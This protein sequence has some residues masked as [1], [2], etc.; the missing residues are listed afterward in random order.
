VFWAMPLVLLRAIIVAMVMSYAF[1]FLTFLR[2]I[3]GE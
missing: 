3:K 2:E 1:N